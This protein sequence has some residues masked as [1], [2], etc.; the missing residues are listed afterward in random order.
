M[1]SCI[2]AIATGPALLNLY[3]TGTEPSVH[4]VTV[5]SNYH[6][7][8]RA[9]FHLS[10][11]FLLSHFNVFSCTASHC[12]FCTFPCTVSVVGV[13]CFSN[14]LKQI[15]RIVVLYPRHD[16]GHCRL[17]V[18]WLLQHAVCTETPNFES[19]PCP[20][21][22]A[23][24]IASESGQDLQVRHPPCVKLSIEYIYNIYNFTV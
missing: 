8:I 16:H 9:V 3:A 2:V 7:N 6:S 23:S 14:A 22:V 1:Y 21:I 4:P 18:M 17:R 11:L 5:C 12:I 13:G 15:I 24:N 10:N 20:V 19:C